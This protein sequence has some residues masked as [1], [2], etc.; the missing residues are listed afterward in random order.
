MEALVILLGQR[1]KKEKEG[2][3][4]QKT[5]KQ[6][7]YFI[8]HLNCHSYTSKSFTMYYNLSIYLYIINH[9]KEVGKHFGKH[10]SLNLIPNSL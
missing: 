10:T 6:S 4:K 7:Q 2:K 3:E 9:E 5:N 1:R 8:I